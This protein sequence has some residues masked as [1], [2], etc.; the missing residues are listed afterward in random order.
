MLYFCKCVITRGKMVTIVSRNFEYKVILTPDRRKIFSTL[1][2]FPVLQ[3]ELAHL[4]IRYEKVS[5]P[6]LRP[7][8]SDLDCCPW[9]NELYKS[10]KRM[11][12]QCCSLLSSCFTLYNISRQLL[13]SAF[14]GIN[15]KKKKKMFLVYFNK[16]SSPRAVPCPCPMFVC[17]A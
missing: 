1:F 3:Q 6:R 8:P 16:D 11:E 15:T 14:F 12:F 10:W 9:R 13:E 4:V 17:G 2:L 7:E 5:T